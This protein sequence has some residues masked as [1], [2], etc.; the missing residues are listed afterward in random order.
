MRAVSGQEP[1]ANRRGV[2]RV[3]VPPA[4]RRQ[5]L[6]TRLPGAPGATLRHRD[7]RPPV[8]EVR[9]RTLNVSDGTSLTPPQD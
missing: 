3:T 6:P 4:G 5:G 2:D 1:R 7:T 9:S 8:I